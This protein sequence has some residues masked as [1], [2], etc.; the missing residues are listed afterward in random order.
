MQ[1]SLLLTSSL[2][3]RS[4]LK[5]MTYL[6]YGIVF[7][8]SRHF[9][10]VRLRCLLDVCVMIECYGVVERIAYQYRK[11]SSHDTTSRVQ[12]VSAFLK[13]NN[14]FPESFKKSEKQ[15]KK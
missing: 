14:V 12:I 3:H 4:S 13:V 9:I 8:L 5:L 11:V 15:N 10:F 2:K 7:E 1:Q 6:C